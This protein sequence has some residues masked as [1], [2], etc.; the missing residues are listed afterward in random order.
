MTR[1]YKKRRLA[2]KAKF[3]QSEESRTV[4]EGVTYKSGVDLETTPTET[5][6]NS[7]PPPPTVDHSASRI[8]FDLET[9]GLG[10]DADIVQISAVCKDKVYNRYVLPNKNISSGASAA[11]GI[12]YDRLNGVLLHKGQPVP[13]V[14]QH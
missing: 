8:F 6:A 7:I 5:Q 12:T 9:T 10:R 1:G 2:T 4:R 3:R 11:T 14:T 13:A